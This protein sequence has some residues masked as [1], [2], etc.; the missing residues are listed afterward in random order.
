MVFIM[1]LD[2]EELVILNDHGAMKLHSAVTR[3][4]MLPPT[5]RDHASILRN[6][7]PWLLNFNLIKHLARRWDNSPYPLNDLE[8]A[9]G[10]F[11]L[12]QVSL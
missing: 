8:M 2:P 5:E 4:M 6:G 10:A 11:S 1:A 7:E 9:A 3:A 12:P